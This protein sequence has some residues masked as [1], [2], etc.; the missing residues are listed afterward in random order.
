MSLCDASCPSH[1]TD[2][3][4]PALLKPPLPPW[5]VFFCA[6]CARG[7]C[8]RRRDTICTCIQ[9]VPILHPP[10]NASVKRLL[11]RA[12]PE[13]WPLLPDVIPVTKIHPSHRILVICARS[14]LQVIRFSSTWWSQR[15]RCGRITLAFPH[16]RS[17][18]KILTLEPVIGR[19]P[20][21]LAVLKKLSQSL[22]SSVPKN[23]NVLLLAFN[24]VVNVAHVNVHCVHHLFPSQHGRDCA[25]MFMLTVFH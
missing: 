8:T 19:R 20:G 6:V 24:R 2:S 7:T 15:L 4:C 14:K 16:M 25:C 12:V 5:F 1:N 11:T 13:H 17:C 22:S 18:N 21:P 23:V 3:P 9:E 10:P